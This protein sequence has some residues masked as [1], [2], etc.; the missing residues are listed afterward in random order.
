MN[1][2]RALLAAIA[3]AAAAGGV[4]MMSSEPPEPGGIVVVSMTATLHPAG[5][6]VRSGSVVVPVLRLQSTRLPDGDVQERMIV[7]EQVPK[8]PQQIADALAS[9]DRYLAAGRPA[10]RKA[11]WQGYAAL[12]EAEGVELPPPRPPED[13]R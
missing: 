8:T 5:A 4:T 10:P 6:E 13:V 11:E 7:V 3:V 1:R 12:L 9:C 2:M